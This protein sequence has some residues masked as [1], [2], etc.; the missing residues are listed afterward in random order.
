MPGKTE[1]GIRLMLL[2]GSVLVGLFGM[3]LGFRALLRPELLLH[4][5][6]FILEERIDSTA[7]MDRLV[8]DRDLGWTG[9]PRYAVDGVSY[10]AQGY[11]TTPG[12]AAATLAEPPI[13]VVG[14]SYA[15]GDEVKDDETWPA[16]LQALVGRRVVNAAVTGYGLDQT[17]LRA[18]QAVARVKPAVLLLG[19]IA[20]DL[21]RSARSRSWGA[22]KPYFDLV[23][24]ALVLRN[25]P[26]PPS[27][28]PAD[29]LSVWQQL[30][31]HS[32]LINEIV[33]DMGWH[34]DWALDHVQVPGGQDGERL[35]CP[36]LRRVA[37]LGV[38]TLVIAEYNPLIWMAP[39]DYVREQRR[40]TAHVLKCAAEA[41]LSTLDLHD[42]IDAAIR[43]QGLEA[44]YRGS[45]P[46]PAGTKLAAERIAAQLARD[47]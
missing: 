22:E 12:P 8:P 3:E 32:L 13:L 10:D 21:W 9:N 38:P 35:A 24:G 44:I 18:E 47:R 45:H 30:F 6:N 4:W 11:R 20:D 25:V 16:Q 29:T 46:S 40:I 7:V 1:T 42:T 33:S 39:D 14:D 19:F 27:P 34:E 31:G 15:H 28:D 2:I 36:L 5:P 41:G 17:V 26:V 43:K 37:A 23:N